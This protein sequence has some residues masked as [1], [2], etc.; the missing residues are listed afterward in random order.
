MCTHTHVHFGMTFPCPSLLPSTAL[1]Q[2]PMELP[3]LP[4]PGILW[5]A[6]CPV[7]LHSACPRQ[8]PSGCL[9]GVF[10]DTL[11]E[12]RS[13]VW[14]QQ[15]EESTHGPGEVKGSLCSFTGCRSLGRAW[16]WRKQLQ[17]ASKIPVPLPWIWNAVCDSTVAVGL[18]SQLCLA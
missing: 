11:L 13:V 16:G 4:K 9:P 15:H 6:A 1:E 18:P 8:M 17:G 12:P 3:A 10:A 7:C 2:L 5:A 14:T